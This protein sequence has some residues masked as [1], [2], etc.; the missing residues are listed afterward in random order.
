MRSRPRDSD[1]GCAGRAPGAR[2]L[3]HATASQVRFLDF[4]DEAG[5]D[6]ITE[7]TAGVIT[8]TIQSDAGVRV[9]DAAFLQKLRAR[10]TEVGALLIFD[11]IQCGMGRTGRLC[12]FERF[13]VVP[14]ALTLGKALGG[15]MPVGALVSSTEHLTKFTF[16]PM[17]GHI[18]TFGGHPVICAAAN[19]TLEVMARDIDFAEVERLGQLLEDL[20]TQDEEVREVRRLGLMFA[21][22]MATPER[23]TEVPPLWPSP[24]PCP[25]LCVTTQHLRGSGMGGESDTPPAPP[26]PRTRPPPP[27][28]VR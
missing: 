3:S 28:P 2:R 5:L 7:Q 24:R 14:D 16:E 17:L 20:L 27:P 8:E 22:D 9:P 4:N 1:R 19:A 21:C 26:N 23:V 13:G 11:E 6:Q 15:G 10:C 18:T 12:A 25:E